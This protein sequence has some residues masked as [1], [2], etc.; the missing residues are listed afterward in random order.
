MDLPQGGDEG[1]EGAVG[2]GP[3]EAA[4]PFRRGEVEDGLGECIGVEVGGVHDD[5]GAAR[6]ADP[7]AG[8]RAEGGVDALQDALRQG[9]EAFSGLERAQGASVLREEDV[10]G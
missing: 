9:A 1:L 8:G 10:G 7:G 2:G 6:D 4:T 5:A 3:A